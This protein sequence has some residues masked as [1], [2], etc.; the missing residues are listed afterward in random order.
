METGEAKIGGGVR[1]SAGCENDKPHKQERSYIY[2]RVAHTPVETGEAKIG[3]GVRDSAGCGNSR[4]RA[5]ISPTGK[6]AVIYTQGLRILLW[7][8]V[9]PK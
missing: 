1:D 6:S 5:V 3:E 8:G 2:T 4:D 7:K 9:R